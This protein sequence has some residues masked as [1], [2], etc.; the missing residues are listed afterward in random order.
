MSIFDMF[1]QPIK[2]TVSSIWL[3][4]AYTKAEMI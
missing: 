1:V 3:P 2:V 4:L